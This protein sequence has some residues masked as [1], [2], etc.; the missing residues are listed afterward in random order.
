[1]LTISGKIELIKFVSHPMVQFWLQ[2]TQIP[3]V[4]IQSINSICDKFIWKSKVHKMS[5]EDVCKSKQEGG[6]SIRK[7]DDMTKAIVII[8]V[9]KF[10]Q[11]DSLWDKWMCNRYCKIQIFALQA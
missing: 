4:A 9:W 6:L 7:F 8:M 5:W 2:F 10:L 3:M 1:M 11:G